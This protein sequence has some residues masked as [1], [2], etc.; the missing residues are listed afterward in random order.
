MITVEKK[1]VKLCGRRIEVLA[2]L[3]A[4]IH[5]VNEALSENEGPEMARSSIEG[6]V[7][8]GFMTEQEAAAEVE[9][10]AD[11]LAGLGLKGILD[12]LEC[13]DGAL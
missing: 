2:E 12:F 3:S 9:K 11:E 1:T 4:V 10:I 13:L 7:R 6:A 5:A 8:I